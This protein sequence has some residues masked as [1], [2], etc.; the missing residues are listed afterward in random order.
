M[1]ASG[2]EGERTSTATD[3][4]GERTWTASGFRLIGLRARRRGQLMMLGE[5]D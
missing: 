5:D 2:D 4:D 3:V 1:R